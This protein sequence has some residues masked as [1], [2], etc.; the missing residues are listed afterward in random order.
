MHFHKKLIAYSNLTQKINIEKFHF[1][2]P[3]H[4]HNN[5]NQKTNLFLKQKVQTFAT[6]LYIDALL[7]LLL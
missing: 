2:I 5:I 6:P 7:F 1:M 3:I 4:E